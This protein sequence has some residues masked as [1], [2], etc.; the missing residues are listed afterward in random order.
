M[1]MKDGGMTV[2]I[3]I[4]G[5]GLL[6]RLGGAL[7]SSNPDSAL[8]EA[9]EEIILFATGKEIDLTPESKECKDDSR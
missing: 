3:I 7:F 4:L 2:F 8:E 1:K 5:I 6:V 9:G